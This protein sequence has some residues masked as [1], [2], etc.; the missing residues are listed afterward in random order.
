MRVRPPG[1]ACSSASS[2]PWPAWAA[3]GPTSAPGRRREPG[4]GAGPRIDGV[5]GEDEWPEERWESG[6]VFPWRDRPPPRPRSSFRADGAALYFAFWVADEDVVVID[7][8][9]GDESLVARGDRVELF[10]AR[11]EKLREYYSIEIDPRG[12]VLDYRA[13]FYRHFDEEWD[14]PGLDVAARRRPGGY[15]VEG[16]I[17]RAGLEADGPVSLTGPTPARGPVPGRVQPPRG[18]RPARELDQLDPTLGADAGLPRALRL[19]V[20]ALRPV[21]AHALSGASHSPTPLAP[22]PR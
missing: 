3:P 4:R 16:R 11:D 15:D 1:R 13:R 2:S 9:P 21:V 18:R 10:L 22:T 19:R 6:L 17:S 5:L 14:C 12:R 8:P 7:G 20:P